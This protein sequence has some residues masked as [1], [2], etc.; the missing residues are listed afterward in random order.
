MERIRLAHRKGSFK[1]E[2]EA[3]LIGEDLIVAIWGGS[4]PHIGATALAMPRSSLR[5]P[6][7]TRS[8]SSVL[9]RLGHREDEI[10][11]RVSE[12]I[13]AALNMVVVVSAGVHWNTLDE[14]D[15]EAI[16]SICEELTERLIQK[17]RRKRK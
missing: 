16:R 1:I 4:K 10:V 12:R 17:V 7:V 11:K 6:A 14:E 15:I 5:D 2:A 13:S 3:L 9:T 8:T